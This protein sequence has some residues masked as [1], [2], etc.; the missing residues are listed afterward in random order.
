MRDIKRL[1][2]L[3]LIL[4]LLLPA[5]HAKTRKGE[6]LLSQGREAEVRKQWETA[7]DFYEQALLEDPADAA[8]QLS[9]R[10][11]RFQASMSRLDAGQKLR[12]Q[13]KL[14]EALHEFQRAYAID[15]SSS[16]AEQE[17][18]RTREMIPRGEIARDTF[19]HC[20]RAGA[21]AGREGAEAG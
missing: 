11:V 9:V 7:L 1:A 17:I 16:I 10:R 8:Y 15:P 21:D 18:K 2:T 3:C 4:C 6:K 14:E 19:Q 20:R 12:A 13:G 5:L